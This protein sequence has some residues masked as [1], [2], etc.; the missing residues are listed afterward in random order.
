M[1]NSQGDVCVYA[2]YLGFTVGFFVFFFDDADGEEDAMA[3][4]YFPVTVS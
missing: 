1:F 4:A 3:G 2:L